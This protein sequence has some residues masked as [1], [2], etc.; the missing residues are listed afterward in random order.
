MK[1]IKYLTTITSPLE[2]AGNE[3]EIKDVSLHV[4][5]QLLHGKYAIEIKIGK[6]KGKTN[7]TKFTELKKPKVQD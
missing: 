5:R 7:A 6:D 3:G 1:K 4:A 2:Q